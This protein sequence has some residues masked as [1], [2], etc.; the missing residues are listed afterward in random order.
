M[1]AT[2]NNPTLWYA[3]PRPAAPTA[4][5]VEVFL[6]IQMACQL[7]LLIPQVGPARSLVRMAAF[8]ASFL[9]L[10]VLAP[11]Y[12]RHPSSWMAIAATAVIGLCVLNP[13]TR[14]LTAGVAQAALYA[15]ILAPVWWVSGLK[16]DPHGFRRVL[17][18]LWAF[19][20]A[21]VLVGAL[22]VL[23]PGALTPPV[24]AVVAGQGAGYVDS[25]KITL[26]SGA[27]VFRP[28]GLTDYP[29]A[30]A[31][32]A[33]YVVLL[34]L[35]LWTDERNPWLKIA[36]V[37]AMPIAMFVLALSQVRSVL[38]M[39]AVCS[40]AFI[41]MLALRGQGQRVVG[42]ITTLGAVVLLSFA[43]AIAVGGETVTRRLLSL[44]DEEPGQVY[45]S[46][47][48]HFLQKTFEVLLPK[49][50]MGAGPGRWGM[51][52]YYFGDKSRPETDEL[53]VEIQWTGWL[54]DGGLPLVLLYCAAIGI[55][56]WTAG[57]IAMDERFPAVAVLGALVLAYDLGSV[58]VTFN[59][60]LFIGQGGM[61]FW[62]LNACLF[63][64]WCHAHVTR[65]HE[66][67]RRAVPRPV[68]MLSM[69]RSSR[70]PMP[71]LPASTTPR[72]AGVA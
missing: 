23:F 68:L 55:A 72:P 41:A 43:W 42:L 22:Q 49:Y 45:Y 12:R 29:G 25:L 38:V 6:A 14:T 3:P 61:E 11:R 36:Y 30:A 20:A 37:A 4:R 1:S 21:S 2:A 63:A 9:M 48:G 47:R 50:P 8:G 70:R 19:H 58:A 69:S 59:Y 46:N 60:P 34:G 66:G 28:M 65:A 26:A 56:I 52:G 18:L 53:W 67:Q 10:L 13:E 44:I 71:L 64:A 51:I 32:A 62:L 16:V 31:T 17:L 7:I 27:R 24:S 57:R 35:G 33:F 54:L 39:T 15:A 5:W 40:F